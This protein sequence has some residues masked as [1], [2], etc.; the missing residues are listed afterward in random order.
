M[1]PKN[2]EKV[3]NMRIVLFVSLCRYLEREQIYM[4]KAKESM[5]LNALFQMVTVIA[6]EKIFLR[7]MF[8]S[9]VG[10]LQVKPQF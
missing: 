3:A 6:K 7:K 2:V 10:R 8:R 1:V 4:L 5:A 9:S